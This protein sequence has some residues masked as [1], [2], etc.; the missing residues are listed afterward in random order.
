M[1]PDAIPPPYA[2]PSEGRGRPEQPR[3]RPADT[4]DVDAILTLIARHF[5][6]SAIRPDEWRRLFAHGWGSGRGIG[7]V[8]DRGG[9]V[10]G[11]LGAIHADRTIGGRTERCCNLTTMCVDTDHRAMA[12]FLIMAASRLRDCTVTDLSPRP[13]VLALLE[14]TGFSRLDDGKLIVPWLPAA[15][16]PT[17]VTVDTDVGRIRAALDGD[18]RR[19]LDD[20]APYGCQPV[21][22]RTPEG[23]CFALVKRRVLRRIV[24]LSEVLYASV[25]DRLSVH[26]AAVV[27]A[28]APCQRTVGVMAD[29]RL[30]GTAPP[31]GFA[32][33][34]PA[35]YRSTR[36]TPEAIDNL[37]TELVLLPM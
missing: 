4:D 6:R 33:K 21:L 11:F 3:V 28:V 14:R 19:I 31:R 16:T 1:T 9:E 24:P 22:L 7:W 35:A 15:R 32:V 17:G 25:P 30:F 29:R 2:S 23:T 18:H 34:S 5:P 12:P 13:S 8:L 10:V 36:L 20:H 26:I 27:R 37:Y